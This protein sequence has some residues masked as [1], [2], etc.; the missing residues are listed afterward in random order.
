MPKKKTQ[1]KTKQN[2]FD[3]VM[4]SLRL[5]LTKCADDVYELTADAQNLFYDLTILGD[6]LA[7]AVDELDLLQDEYNSD[8]KTDHSR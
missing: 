5:D 1:R 3:A 2:P 4:A 6:S 7:A 8:T